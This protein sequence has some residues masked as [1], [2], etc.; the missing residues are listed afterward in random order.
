LALKLAD[1]MAACV[2]CADEI[3]ETIEDI[4]VA[5]TGQAASHVLADV[6]VSSSLRVFKNGTWVP[7]SR[8]NG[9][10]YFSNTNSI[11]FF[12]SFRPDPESTGVDDHIAVTYQHY[13]ITTKSNLDPR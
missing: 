11:A 8:Q 4:I 5:A 13:Q 6:P 9:F 10:D 1:A 2:L 3:E 12:G 7:R